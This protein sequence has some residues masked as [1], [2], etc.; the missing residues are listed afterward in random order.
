M[1][2]RWESLNALMGL[3]DEAAPGTTFR[4]FTDEL[5]ERQASQHEPTVAAVTL[6]TLHSAKGLEWDTCTSSALSEGLLPI[7][8][9]HDARADRRGAPPALRRRHAGPPRARAELGAGRAPGSARRGSRSRFLAE[10]RRPAAPRLPA[11]GAGSALRSWSARR[12]RCARMPRPRPSRRSAARAAISRAAASRPRPIAAASRASAPRRPVG[13]LGAR[14]PARPGRHPGRVRPGRRQNRHGAGS[15]LHER[16][17]R[18]RGCRRRR[19][20]GAARRAR[21]QWP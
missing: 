4:A 11:A 3:A 20:A 8:Y 6:A 10:L 1:R 7:S 18:A 16:A 19:P 14:W 13:Q 12:G 5:I 2:D 21:S 15:R 17:D 9:A